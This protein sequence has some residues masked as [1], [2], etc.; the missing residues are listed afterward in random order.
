MSLEIQSPQLQLFNSLFIISLGLG[1]KTYDYLPDNKAELP[2][3]YIGEQF[4][5]DRANKST[6]HGNVQQ[7]IHVYGNHRQ[8]QLVAEMVGKL[9][10][11]IR[12]LKH[13]DSFNVPVVNM[14]D[15]TLIDNSTTT[16]LIHG[17]L[18][19]EFSFN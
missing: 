3:V 7:T 5:Q 11:K 16:T 19:V 1:Y 4:S 9:R 2:F 8:R 6:V 15:Q 18:E 13:T 17:I 10:Y 12:E 14:N